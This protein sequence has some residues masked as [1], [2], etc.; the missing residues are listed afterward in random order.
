MKKI[1]LLSIL[2]SLAMTS[3]ATVWK[4]HLVVNE[5]AVVDTGIVV[6]R[7]VAEG[8]FACVKE[9]KAARDSIVVLREIA[10]IDDQVIGWIEVDL[11][12]EKGLKVWWKRT[13][14]V[15]RGFGIGVLVGIGL[16]L[17]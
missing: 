3:C 9:L 5:A 8:C 4:K 6:S 7:R 16:V 10:V 13:K 14:G 11:K 12:K 2:M 15:M 17:L 1:G